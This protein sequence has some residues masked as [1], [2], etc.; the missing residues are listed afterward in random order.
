MKTFKLV[1]SIMKQDTI[2]ITTTA[3]TNQTVGR[4]HSWFLRKRSDL[5]W[6]WLHRRR[7]PG[8]L[9]QK[10]NRYH[11]GEIRIEVWEKNQGRGGGNG[12]TPLFLRQQ[13]PLKNVDFR[14]SG[15]YYTVAQR[16]REANNILR[17]SAA[18]KILFLA[19][20]NKIHPFKPP[21]NVFF[22]II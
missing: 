13:L 19:R 22:F 20:E 16:Y 8:M 21:C 5:S 17:T 12:R 10:L 7:T 14:I 15:G 3:L 6:I 18:S 2:Q 1:R 4:V 9:W 11:H